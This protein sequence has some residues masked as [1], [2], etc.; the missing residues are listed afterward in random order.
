MADQE[1]YRLTR[2]MD[3][4]QSLKESLKASSDGDPELLADMIEGETS[5]FE[6]IE[7]ILLS[8]DDDAVLLEGLR[9]RIAGLSERESRISK[10]V[11]SKRAMILQALQI[12]ELSKKEFP[13]ATLSVGKV[14]PSL[15]I[16]SE[17]AIP[18]RFFKQPN[19][20]LSKAELKKALKDGEKIEGACLSNGGINL[21]IRRK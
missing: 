20:V 14:Q 19:P 3:A 5:L 9:L 10:R 18:S 8:L 13:L 4:A 7:K 2:E 21:T 15:I 12:A 6:M 1:A 17:A 16:D 11:D